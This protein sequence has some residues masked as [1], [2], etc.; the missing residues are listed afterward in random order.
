MRFESIQ[1]ILEHG[2]A[3][4]QQVADFYRQLDDASA[5][6]RVRLLLD[7]LAAHEQHLADTLAELREVSDPDVLGSWLASIPEPAAF[8]QALGTPIRSD[9]EV[10]EV[11]EIA[12]RFD[13]AMIN[14]YQTLAEHADNEAVR[15]LLNNLTELENLEMRRVVRNVGMIQ[16]L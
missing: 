6:A 1:D 13:D 8:T 14:L 7:Y 9:M 3:M 11:L 4:H 5:Q 15:D 16:D 2:R 10:D 12:M